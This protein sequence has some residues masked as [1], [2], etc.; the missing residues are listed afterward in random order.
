MPITPGA[1]QIWKANYW[2][3][4]QKQT[5]QSQEGEVHP[6][7]KLK[8]KYSEDPSA[9]DTLTLANPYTHLSTEEG[10]AAYKKIPSEN[11]PSLL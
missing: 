11:V 8:T 6:T 3:F 10:K 7:L 5:D 1:G 4:A 9:Q 2:T